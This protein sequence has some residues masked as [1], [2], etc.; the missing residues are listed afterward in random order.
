MK[1]RFGVFLIVTASAMALSHATATLRAQTPAAQST[2]SGIYTTDQ[3]AKGETIYADKC[4]RCHG[5]DL[6]GA[7][8]PTLAG[9][10]FASNWDGLDVGQLFDRVRNTMPRKIRSR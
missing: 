2:W 4:A 7:D 10:E 8:A 3:A 5:A 6:S 1:L 9:G